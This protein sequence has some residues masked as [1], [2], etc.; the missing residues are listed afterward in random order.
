MNKIVSETK[1]L[2]F[3]KCDFELTNIEIEKESSEYCAH[4]F[5]IDELKILFRSAKITPTKTGQFVTLWKRKNEKSEI[6]PFEISDD[7]D[8]FVINVKTEANFGQFVFP[9]SVLVERGIITDKKEGKRA[10]RVYPIWDLTESK[11]AKKTQKWQLD[12]FLEIPFDE[13][14]DTNRAKSLYLKN[15]IFTP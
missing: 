8:L 2:L 14:L 15:S 7:I 4:R 10:V 1:E 11:Q 5:E 3:D 9:K 13:P 12:Y 6:E